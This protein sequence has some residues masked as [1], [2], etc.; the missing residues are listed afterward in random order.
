M[1]WHRDIERAFARN[2]HLRLASLDTFPDCR[3]LRQ[4]RRVNHRTISE[5][6]AEVLAGWGDFA[7]GKSETFVGEAERRVT[8]AV[9]L[10]H[11]LEDE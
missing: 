1:F 2:A 5:C 8:E 9:L 4:F 3:Q 10:D 7:P 6:L 11:A